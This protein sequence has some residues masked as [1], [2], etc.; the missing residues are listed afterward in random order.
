M[1]NNLDL[2][3][4]SIL[5]DQAS[6]R[7]IEEEFTSELGLDDGMDAPSM[8]GGLS[9][10]DQGNELMANWEGRQETHHMFI[11]SYD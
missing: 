8:W 6:I 3:S 4:V 11:Q 1:V 2:N 7:A 5:N 10:T 9:D